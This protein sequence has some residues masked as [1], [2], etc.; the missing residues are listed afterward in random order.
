MK[1]AVLMS[2]YNGEAYIRQ[3]LDSILSQQTDAQLCLIV[4]DDGSSDNTTA[5]LQS[6]ADMGKLQWYT[7]Q[8]LRPAHSFLDLLSKHPDYDFYAF[9][10]QDDYWYPEKLSCGLSCIKDQIGPAMYFANA[11]LVDGDLAPL[12]RN[13]YNRI[14]HHDFYSLVCNGGILGCTI[15]FNNVLAQLIQNAPTPKTMIMHDAYLSIVCAMFD[16][17]IFYD[18]T[19]HMDY[20]QH[21]HNVVGSN[22]KKT[23]ALKDR[24]KSIIT[25]SR[26][27]VADQAQSLL[28]C[29]PELANAE[30]LDFLKK[31]AQYR[32]SLLTACSLA[33]SGKPKY[34]GKS[35]AVTQRLATV[36]R[37]K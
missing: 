37:N 1:I 12:G 30:K 20:R 26:I 18:R 6:Y 31:V 2:T 5:I 23:S 17:T 28:D 14:P 27:S 9:A 21:G 8:N 16:G 10:D 24:L 35:M 3:Q 33:C 29:Y 11:R 7:G 19:A 32:T 15:V 34:N 22:W 13:V 4:R 36:F 25:P